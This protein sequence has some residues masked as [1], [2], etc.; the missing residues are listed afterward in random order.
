VAFNLSVRV[1]VAALLFAL[2]GVYTL[3][4]QYQYHIWFWVPFGM[5]ALIAAIGLIFR[6]RWSRWLAYFV[7]V[8]N[9]GVLLF[10]LAVSVRA[11]TFP[12]ETV[13]LTALGLVPGFVIVAGTIWSTDVVRRRFRVP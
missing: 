7:A 8:V 9:I 2:W 10:G 1:I 4:T 3:W 12:Y 5:A 11:H 13:E 6:W